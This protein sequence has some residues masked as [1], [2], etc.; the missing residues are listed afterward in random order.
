MKSKASE[1][2][3]VR[4]L[5]WRLVFRELSNEE[6]LELAYEVVLCSLMDSGCRERA[7]EALGEVARSSTKKPT[8]K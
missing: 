1:E 8:Q 7:L 5:V 3:S 4:N 2:D 6:M